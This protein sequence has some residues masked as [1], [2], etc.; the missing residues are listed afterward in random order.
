MSQQSSSSEAISGH[1]SIGEVVET[2][3][4]MRD[5]R[6]P[7]AETLLPILKS[8][9][10]TEPVNETDVQTIWSTFATPE[11]VE[12]L[13]YNIVKFNI[14][15]SQ[16]ASGYIHLFIETEM[17]NYHERACNN[18][19][20]MYERQKRVVMAEVVAREAARKAEPGLLHRGVSRMAHKGVRA[21]RKACMR[22]M[23]HDYLRKI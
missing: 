4:T 8:R 21:V 12:A 20:A 22:R 11:W 3:K 9:L 7:M 13:F 10:R 5:S 17:L 2:Y 6:H 18:I 16:P 1:Q 23:M 14:F 19:I 15:S